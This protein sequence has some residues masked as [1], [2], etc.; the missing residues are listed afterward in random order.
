MLQKNTLWHQEATVQWGRATQVHV[1][2]PGHTERGC[3]SSIFCI[4]HWWHVPPPHHQMCLWYWVQ[5]RLGNAAMNTLQAVLRKEQLTTK[6]SMLSQCH[7]HNSV[8]G[9]PLQGGWA[10]KGSRRGHKNTNN[11]FKVPTSQGK[12]SEISRKD[13]AN[14]KLLLRKLV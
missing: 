9:S 4:P 1:S 12:Y 7:C 5:G 6:D 8:T 13:F 10:N 3:F 14:S 11:Q 2:S